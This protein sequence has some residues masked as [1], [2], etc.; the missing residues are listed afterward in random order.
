MAKQTVGELVYKISGDMTQL[1]E[2]VKRS[3]AEINKLKDSMNK[4]QESTSKTAGIFGKLTSVVKGFAVAF[5]ANKVI[6]FAQQGLQLATA[7]LEQETKLAQVLRTSQNATDSQI[8]SLKNQATELERI[9]VLGREV[10]TAVQAQAATFD[11]QADSIERLTPAILNYV[12][13][14][15]GANAS[16][17]EA[18]SLTNG[19]AQALQGKFASLTAVGF[20]LDEETKKMISNG[21]ET[22]RVTALAEVL[23]STYANLNE[24]MAG[25]FLGTQIKAQ[26]AINSFKEDLGFALMPAISAVSG[27]LVGLSKEFLG[28]ADRVNV[29]GKALYQAAQ[30]LIGFSR[31]IETVARVFGVGLNTIKLGYQTVTKG[32]LDVS[33]TVGKAV[34]QDVTTLETMS[35]GMTEMMYETTDEL[36]GSAGEVKDSFLGMGEAFTEAFDPKK[37]QSITEADITALNAQK[38]ATSAFGEETAEAAKEIETMQNK[39]LDLVDASQKASASLREDFQKALQETNQGLAEIVVEAENKIKE[40]KK[41]K[42]DEDD[43]DRKKEIQKE[44][45]AQE[46]ILDAREGFEKRQAERLASIRSRLE[47]AGIETNDIDSL[48]EVKTLEDQIREERRIADLDEFTRFEEQ[49]F[50]KIEKIVEDIIT[51][52]KLET[53]LTEFLVSQDSTRQKSV[54]NF[55]AT[56]IAKYGE[57]AS[58]LRSAISLQERLNSLRGGGAPK[59]FHTGGMVGASGGEVHAGEY[60]IPAHM[61]AKMGSLVSSLESSRRGGNVDNS[62]I[63]NAPITMNNVVEGGADYN[64]MSKSLAWELGRL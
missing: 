29:W 33:A 44:I 37:Y 30:I 40:L 52:R 38:D 60:V 51:R 36:V 19:L 35:T 14:E 26:Q 58:A 1:Q 4:T 39:M 13:A 12:V 31:T 28:G 18:Q 3:E 15:K 42:K 53:E 49:E 9:G 54:E 32:L 45:D 24:T 59:Q 50:L 7:R 61:V 62:R 34:G 16:A 57:M 41:Q 6:Q 11:L 5:V 56:A 10:V 27:E 46:E 64:A 20:V 48:L 2:A 43:A 21:T 47:E 17:E 25:T 8:Q 22:E 63:V 55:A 23:D